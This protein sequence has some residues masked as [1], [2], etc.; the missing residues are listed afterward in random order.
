METYFFNTKIFIFI[1]IIKNYLEETFK[2]RLMKDLAELNKDG[3]KSMG[4]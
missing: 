2:V 3:H 1:S 4:N